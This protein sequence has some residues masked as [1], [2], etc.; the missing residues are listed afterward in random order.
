VDELIGLKENVIMGRLIPA[1]TGTPFY[2]D[3]LV[4]VEE[5]E[6]PEGG[7]ATEGGEEVQETLEEV[8]QQ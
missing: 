4:K 7:K 3:T 8:A 1:G 6:E 5:P 2:R